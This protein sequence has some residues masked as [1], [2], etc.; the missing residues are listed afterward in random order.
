MD[1]L[2]LLAVIYLYCPIMWGLLGNHARRHGHSD[3]STIKYAIKLFKT[4]ERD[5]KTIY[6]LSV[7]FA[8]FLPLAFYSILT[9]SNDGFITS[10]AVSLLLIATVLAAISFFTSPT[11]RAIYKKHTTSLNAS[12]VILAAIN[13]SVATSYAESAIVYLTGVRAS[14]LPTAMSWL[15]IIM[16]PLAWMTMLA[17]RFLALYAAALFG[18]GVKSGPEFNS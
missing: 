18:A 8:L 15:S 16:V 10:S 2:Y 5:E 14:E 3:T 1:A 11:V 6:L 9:K 7:L 17:T 12:V 4:L 13:Y